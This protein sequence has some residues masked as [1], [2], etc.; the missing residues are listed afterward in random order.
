MRN[1]KFREMCMA[2]LIFPVQSCLPRTYLEILI[3]DGFE[4]SGNWCLYISKVSCKQMYP[5]YA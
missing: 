4:L 1:V 3:Y 5:H 2:L